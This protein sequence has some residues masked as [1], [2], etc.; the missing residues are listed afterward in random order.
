MA[1]LNVVLFL[2]VIGVGCLMGSMI[3]SPLFSHVFSTRGSELVDSKTAMTSGHV[4]SHV[5]N[6]MRQQSAKMDLDHVLFAGVSPERDDEQLIHMERIIEK[7]EGEER[8]ERTK[9]PEFREMTPKGT[10]FFK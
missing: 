5:M 6:A 9:V 4:A 3:V 1:I 2:L 7:L 10:T 8:S